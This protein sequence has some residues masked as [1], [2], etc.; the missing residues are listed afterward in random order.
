MN[1]IVQEVWGV[2]L[3]V[4]GLVCA[5]IGFWFRNRKM[6]LEIDRLRKLA[7]EQERLVKPATL[8]EADRLVRIARKYSRTFLMILLLVSSVGV[9]APILM[10]GAR[11]LLDAYDERSQYLDAVEEVDDLLRQLPNELEL[12]AAMP[13]APSS[14]RDLLERLAQLTNEL[15]YRRRGARELADQEINHLY[16]AHV[17]ESVVGDTRRTWDDL[18]NLVQDDPARFAEIRARARCDMYPSEARRSGSD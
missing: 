11:L 7:A 17:L 2:L 13:D 18:C 1:F 4:A 9:I 8:E 14:V 3:G 6:Q 12:R 15:D 10:P 16:E 5:V